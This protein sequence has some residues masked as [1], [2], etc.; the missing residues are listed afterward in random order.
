[1][2]S[3]MSKK[4]SN[5]LL[6]INHL[7][8][9]NFKKLQ[10]AEKYIEKD[11]FRD[12]ADSINQM[13]YSDYEVTD[14]VRDSKLQNNHNYTMRSLELSSASL[15]QRI[16]YFRQIANLTQKELAEQCDL[17]ESTIRNYELGNR[18]P[19][20]DT[21]STIS[22]V[23]EVSIFALMKAKDPASPQSALKFLFDMEKY[24]MMKP[25]EIDGQMYLAFDKPNYNLAEM[26]PDDILDTVLDNTSIMMEQIVRIWSRFYKMFENGDIDEDTYLLWQNKYP[27][28]ATGK[29][30]DIFGTK[31]YNDIT[32]D[33]KISETKKRFRKTKVE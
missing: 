3:K 12:I 2:G 10:T 18:Y 30:N 15:G 11:E 22:S 7:T 23:L 17:N 29:T 5:K 19:D 13:E 32:I 27:A 26:T 9:K 8:K 25:V 31:D 24:Y 14:D 1:M 6:M 4:D 21:L 28:F 33:Q 16:R 20:F